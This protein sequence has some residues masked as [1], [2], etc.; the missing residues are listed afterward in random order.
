VIIDHGK[1]FFLEFM[2]PVHETAISDTVFTAPLP[3]GN[4]R[5]AVDAFTDDPAPLF[6]TDIE[7]FLIHNSPP[8]KMTATVLRSL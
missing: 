1:G 6:G 2:L 4:H 8:S 7:C 3:L 5:I